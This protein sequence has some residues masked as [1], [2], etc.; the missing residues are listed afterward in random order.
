M[1][2]RSGPATL[3]RHVKASLPLLFLPTEHCE[4]T[5]RLAIRSQVCRAVPIDPACLEDPKGLPGQGT[6]SHGPSP[7]SLHPSA[8][9]LGPLFQAQP[10]DSKIWQLGTGRKSSRQPSSQHSLCSPAQGAGL[11]TNYAP[12]LARQGPGQR[13]ARSPV[14]LSLSFPEALRRTIAPG[15]FLCSPKSLLSLISFP[16]DMYTHCF[17]S[18][19]I[20]D[21]MVS[22]QIKHEP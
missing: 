5:S 8:R 20:P 18:P 19:H 14:P 2:K 16:T 11:G 17:P 4:Q 1:N 7:A 3:K 15:S 6:P 9:L 12:G 10:Q 21:H 13:T 22:L